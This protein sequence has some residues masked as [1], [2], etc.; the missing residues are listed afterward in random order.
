MGFSNTS[1]L[2]SMNK[3]PLT[4]TIYESKWLIFTL[5]RSSVPLSLIAKQSGKYTSNRHYNLIFSF[6]K[7]IQYIY[8]K[9]VCYPFKCLI[10]LQC[11]YFLSLLLANWRHDF[12]WIMVT[13][14][15]RYFEN[16]RFEWIVF[17]KPRSH[18]LIQRLKLKKL[19]LFSTRQ[20]IWT[21]NIIYF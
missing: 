14:V 3:N 4:D 1:K 17:S 8:I 11:T 21:L 13:V 2:V 19:Y 7:N 6:S 9:N 15:V 10:L 18:F 20:W 16:F 12:L 5:T